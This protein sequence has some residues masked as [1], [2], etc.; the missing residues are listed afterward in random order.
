MSHLSPADVGA[1]VTIRRSLGGRPTDLVGD[2][3]SW[4]GDALAIRRRDGELVRVPAREVVAGHVV[5]P[6]LRAA[7]ELEGVAARG[8]RAPDSEWLGEWWMRAAGG[9]TSRANAVRPLGSPGV[10]TDEA[11]RVA[12]A[13]YAQRGLPAR[14]QCVVGAS[15][16]RDLR[17]RGWVADPGVSVMTATIARVLSSN[18]IHP[19]DVVLRGEPSPEWLALFRG[20]EVPPS[21]VAIL[22]GAPTVTFASVPTGSG[23]LAIG[24]AA[25]EKPWVGLTAIEV[26]EGERRRGHARA[27]IAALLRWARE[28]GAMRVYLEVLAS[29]APAV[30]LYESL[31]FTEHHRYVCRHS[32]DTSEA[33]SC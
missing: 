10:D 13:W 17:R 20:G 23:V 27:V 14:V 18:S 1:R 5:G 29:N 19:D 32:P 8:W 26:L 22:T 30:A 31:G 16:D 6:S 11:L 21:G 9:F 7:I 4:D 24:R 28:Q 12:A 2:L 33:S 3:E 15:V 25:V